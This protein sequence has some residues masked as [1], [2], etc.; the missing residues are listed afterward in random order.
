MQTGH[1]RTSKNG[2]GENSLLLKT[3]HLRPP[4]PPKQKIHV[5]TAGGL[6]LQEGGL[7]AVK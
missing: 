6:Q 3:K 1:S 5:E 7:G 2:P 4:L